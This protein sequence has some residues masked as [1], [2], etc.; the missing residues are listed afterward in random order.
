MI[1]DLTEIVNDPEIAQSFTIER[2]TVTFVLGGDQTAVTP[3]TAFGVITVADAD[4]LQMI[5]EA[6][7][8]QSAMSFYTTTPIVLSHGNEPQLS[9]T[10]GTQGVSDVLIWRGIR[11]RISKV[12]P[13]IDYGYFHAVGVKVEAN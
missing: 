5:P 10:S 11:F 2:S 13:Y 7:R 9:G 3:I 12:F 1:V 4:T 8:T 6:D